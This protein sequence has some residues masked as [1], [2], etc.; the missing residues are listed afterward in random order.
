MFQAGDNLLPGQLLEEFLQQP[1][2]CAS[3]L[4]SA[5]AHDRRLFSRNLDEQMLGYGPWLVPT[6]IASLC[7]LCV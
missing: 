6:C 1:Q 2:S 3:E 5:F 4:Q 7:F